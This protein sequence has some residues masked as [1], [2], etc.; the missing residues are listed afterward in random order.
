MIRIPNQPLFILGDFETDLKISCRSEYGPGSFRN[1]SER[2]CILQL[3]MVLKLPNG[4]VVIETKQPEPGTFRVTYSGNFSLSIPDLTDYNLMNAQEKLLFEEKAGFYKSAYT[5]DAQEQ[6]FLDSL[7]NLHMSN[8]ARGV[9]TYWLSE[10]LRVALVHKHNIYAEGGDEA[11]RYGLGVTYNG[12]DGVMEHSGNDLIGCNF[13][14][15]YRK[16]QFRFYNKMSFDYSKEDNPTVKFSEYANANPYFEKR[17]ADG[18][19]NRYLEEYYTVNQQHYTIENPLYNASLNSFDR[20]KKVNFVNNFNA[21]WRP[22][23][24]VMV[25]ARVGVGKKCQKSG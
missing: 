11:V 16:G 4:V 12:T 13:D 7:Y 19:V 9:N 25:R 24:T 23:E 5:Y 10:P 8:V 6:L 2:C 14:L 18:K 1:D 20:A 15:T 3:Y 21:E 17:D 22:V